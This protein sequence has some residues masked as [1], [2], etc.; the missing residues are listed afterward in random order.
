MLPL[1]TRAKSLW[2][3]SNGIDDAGCAA[4]AAILEKGALSVCER[5]DIAGNAIRDEGCRALATAVRKGAMPRLKFLC[6]HRNRDGW[7]NLAGEDARA[8]LQAACVSR[9]AGIGSST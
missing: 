9:K 7:Q 3:V 1:C 2:L 8:E 4:I 6:F 5:I